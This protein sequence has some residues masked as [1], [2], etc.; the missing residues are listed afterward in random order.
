M[1]QLRS[2]SSGRQL[3]RTRAYRTPTHLSW[4]KMRTRCLNPNA[5]QYPEYG[6]R[7]IT[8]D[9][10]W[11]DYKTFLADMGERPSKDFTL[12]RKD[13]NG[14]YCKD[15]C[16]WAS[17]REQQNN[18]RNTKFLTANGETLPIADWAR[19][20]GVHRVRLWNRVR[21]GWSDHDVVNTPLPDRSIARETPSYHTSTLPALP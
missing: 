7:G 1:R 3:A 10:A 4:E 6:G 11:D 9:P 13:T 16:R 8:I 5:E 19:R 15:N 18:R 2:R 20:I 14:P 12:D 21:I 17:K